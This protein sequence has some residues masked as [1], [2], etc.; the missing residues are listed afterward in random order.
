MLIDPHTAVAVSA[1]RAH[2]RRDQGE[3]PMVALANFAGCAVE[4]AT[5]IRPP[6]PPALAAIMEQPEHVTVL[7]NDVAAV[8][9]FIRERARLRARAA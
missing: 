9:R 7:P 6:L 8:A 5:D 2:R 4:R 3:A 1:A